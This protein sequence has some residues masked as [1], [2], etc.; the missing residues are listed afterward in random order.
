MKINI[1]VLIC[2]LLG[3]ASSFEDDY[4]DD[5]DA[6]VGFDNHFDDFIVNIADDQKDLNFMDDELKNMMKDSE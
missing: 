2:T 3:S 6:M 5:S 4:F 1:F